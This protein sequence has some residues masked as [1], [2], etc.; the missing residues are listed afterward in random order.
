MEILQE[1]S[2]GPDVVRLQ[3]ELRNRGFSPGAIDGQFGPGTE[4][5]VLAF[6]KSEGLLADGKAGPRTLAA[7]GF[8]ELPRAGDLLLITVGFT[9]KL[10]PTTPLDSIKANLPLLLDALVD[11]DLATADMALMELATIR[12]EVGNFKPISEFISRFNTAPGG[13]PFGLYDNRRDL[14]N[15]GPPDGERFR[16]RG[17]VQV[18]GRTNY[19]RCSKALGLGTKLLEEPDLANDPNIASRVI[20]RFL[21]DRERP[22]KEALVAGDLASARRLINGGSHGLAEFQSTFAL[23]QRLLASNV[24]TGA[25]VQRS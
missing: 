22:I 25:P 17:F 9:S 11:V 13:Q 10:F 15:Q 20:A 19:E 18:T 2:N 8:D 1:S 4:A 23:G 6:Q 14:G 12:V 24:P 21:K 16:G 7:L 5:A 3:T